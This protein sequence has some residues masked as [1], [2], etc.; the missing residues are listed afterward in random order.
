MGKGDSAAAFKGGVGAEGEDRGFSTRCRR[1]TKTVPNIPFPRRQTL[2]ATDEKNTSKRREF[3]SKM[4]LFFA[5]IWA[6]SF[7]TSRVFSRLF[8]ALICPRF[9]LAESR[10]MPNFAKHS[11]AL[12]T[13]RTLKPAAL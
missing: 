5:I 2:R 3:R 1:R 12:D 7:K 8:A 11:F 13:G 9:D 4:S 10:K 6:L